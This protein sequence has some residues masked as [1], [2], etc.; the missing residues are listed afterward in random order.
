MAHTY[1]MYTVDANY[2]LLPSTEFH[3]PIE[4]SLF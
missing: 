1:I 4:E 2:L 3:P